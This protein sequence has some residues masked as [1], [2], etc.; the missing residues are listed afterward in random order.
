MT[1]YMYLVW[2]L[3]D[4]TDNT[5]GRVIDQPNKRNTTKQDHRATR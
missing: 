1:T 5:T 2:P 4:N 3:D